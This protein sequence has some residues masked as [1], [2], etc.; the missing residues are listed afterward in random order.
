MADKSQQN[1]MKQLVYILTSI[2]LFF[3]LTNCDEDL[4]QPDELNLITFGI[5]QD[6]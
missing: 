6:M 2:F 1:I 3:G 5:T 4:N